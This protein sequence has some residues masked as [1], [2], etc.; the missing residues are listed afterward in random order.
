MS[1]APE[2]FEQLRKLLTL[3]RHEQPPPGYFRDFSS[4]VMDGIEAA[5]SRTGL[6]RLWEEAPWLQRFFQS[7]ES[8]SLFAGGFAASICA[9]LLGG[10][11]YSQY[12]DEP[13][14]ATT[15][16]S[17]V[18]SLSVASAMAPQMASSE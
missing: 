12:V 8:N 7:L 15:S 16:G 3:K 13:A 1:N 17:D 2:D 4:H 5:H 14:M 9:L 11:V 18:A 10:I 6:E